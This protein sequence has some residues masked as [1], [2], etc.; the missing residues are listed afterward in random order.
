[1]SRYLGSFSTEIDISKYLDLVI[2]RPI[3][4]SSCLCVKEHFQRKLFHQNSW[5]LIIYRP[6][7]TSSCL[8]V[9]DHLQRN[10][11]YQN[12]WNLINL[13]A[14]CYNIIVARS[15]EI[16]ILIGFV[17]P[18][19]LQVPRNIFCRS[20]ST[21]EVSVWLIIGRYIHVV[22]RYL[23]SSSTK[24]VIPILLEFDYLPARYIHVV[25]KYIG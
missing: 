19:C 9:K 17:I 23:G 6:D 12:S 14:R 18:S 13:S 11:F 24:I 22:S 8:C 3:I 20:F 4:T 2:Y 5:N 15:T 7:I 16:W 1:M 21:K 25:S 10:K